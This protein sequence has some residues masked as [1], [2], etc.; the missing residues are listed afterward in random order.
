[1]R[2]N[3]SKQ[4]RTRARTTGLIGPIGICL[5][6]LMLFSGQ[7]GCP[8]L[9]GPQGPEGPTGPAGPAGPGGGGAGGSA[10]PGINVAVQS[11]DFPADGKPEVEFTMKDDY[12][13][14]V[15]LAEFG[16]GDIRFVLGYLGTPEELDLG[17]ANTSIL[18][19]TTPRYINYVT[20]EEEA[21]PATGP[22]AGDTIAAGYDHAR[23]G[24]VT[25]N[26]DGSFS[27]KFEVEVPA[28]F[29]QDATHQLSGQI[30]RNF[31]VDGKRYNANPV[32]T[33]RPDGMAV[34]ETREVVDT[35][36]CNAC[37]TRLG[38][39][40]GSRR[41]I[42]YC[43][44]CHNA[45]SI[46]ANTGNQVDFAIM[47]HKIHRGAD[48]PSVQAGQPYQ[49]VGYRD[50]VHDYSHV[51]FPQD[52]RNCTV[53]HQSAPQAD[54]YLNSPTRAGC[55]ACHDR[56]WFGLAADMPTGFAAHSGGA[57][58]DDVGCAGCH[59]P[60][61]GLAGILDSHLTPAEEEGVVLALDITNVSVDATGTVLT[62][63]FDA[64][65][66]N[67]DPIED[68]E[69][70]GV[71]AGIVVAWPVPEYEEEI[72]EF[73]VGFGPT[74][75]NLVNNTGGSYSYTAVGALPVSSDTFAVGMQGR[76][77]FDH[78]G[79]T[80]TVGIAA[81]DV[82]LFTTDG[83]VPVERRTVVEEESCNKC[84]NEVRMHGELRVGVD[85]CL[86]CHNVNQTDL[87]YRDDSD[88]LH[89]VTDTVTVNFKDMIHKIHMSHELTG[90]YTVIGYGG[91]VHD[92]KEVHFPG[93][94]RVCSICHGDNDIDPPLTAEAL[95]TVV[96]NT[97][98][99]PTSTLPEAAA[100]T[101]CHDGF[102]AGVHA[103]LNTDFANNV[104]TCAICHGDG[105]DFSIATVHDPGP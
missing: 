104:E 98:D 25:Q 105:A 57:M 5:V 61:G 65:D 19:V 6:A 84:H 9:P 88:E 97:V 71:G 72:S 32:F 99:D 53:C 67:G 51:E 8:G 14:P 58:D 18:Q 1:M 44:M 28:D 10:A 87:P 48:L 16:S 101:S 11:V 89:Q 74:S 13:N 20:N 68:L 91:S 60:S 54:D 40:G 85:L 82:I 4:R 37:H 103:G 21:D 2:Q 81:S 78:E 43:I 7:A 42:Q 49:I 62:V 90:E 63:D 66:G 38:I 50:A 92:Y 33:F 83:S 59:P 76:Q 70:A 96:D 26:A 36:T 31:V 86:M 95:P 17:S 12:G 56:S 75:A 3:V 39:H 15:S 94:V 73:F 23:T 41:E 80:E 35:A 29:P 93:D 24:G 34:T 47:T 22:N 64:A 27:Y 45:Q 102:L 77:S 55:G 69:A 79:D 46:D 100:C 30:N 52:V